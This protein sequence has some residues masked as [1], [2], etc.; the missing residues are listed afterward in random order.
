MNTRDWLALR[1]PS[2]PPVLR[3]RV[4]VL[5]GAVAERPGDPA[6]TLIDAAEAALAALARRRTADRAAALDLLAVD[7]LVTYAFESAARAP[8][9][10]PGRSSDAMQRL[11]RAAGSGAGVGGAR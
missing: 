2:P 9:E 4:E 6:G 10:I 1:E 5:V 7:A 3:E 8:H 11:S